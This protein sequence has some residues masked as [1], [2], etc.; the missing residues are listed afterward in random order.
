MP[1]VVSAAANEAPLWPAAE[2]VDVPPASA[3][4]S[5]RGWASL[6]REDSMERQDTRGT[7]QKQQHQPARS[8]R[9]S[10][11]P[12]PPLPSRPNKWPVPHQRVLGPPSAAAA[13]AA[14]ATGK[15]SSPSAETTA[16]S[17]SPKAV[18]SSSP[19][20][21][22]DPA[23]G[24]VPEEL[25]PLLRVGVSLMARDC[26]KKWLEAKIEALHPA[27]KEVTV[28]FKG[29]PTAYNENIKVT[30]KRLR[31]HTKWTPVE[32]A[33]GVVSREVKRLQVTGAG[34]KANLP[35]VRRGLETRGARRREK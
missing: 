10:P 4:S 13:A 2:P 5:A 32:Q 30:L 25:R 14:T 9:T 29:W 19:K 11:S 15:T 8:K 28:K 17:T 22:I 21:D 31:P 6:V 24:E 16:K 27:R 35:E 7:D 20:H 23:W 33:D 1:V 3:A 34:S 26:A 18:P 12:S